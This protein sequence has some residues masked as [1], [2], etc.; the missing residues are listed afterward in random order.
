MRLLRARY[1]N[2]IA[3]LILVITAAIGWNG[4][5]LCVTHHS[6]SL[7]GLIPCSCPSTSDNDAQ[8]HCDAEEASTCTCACSVGSPTIPSSSADILSWQARTVA[9]E[10]ESSLVTVPMR[11]VVSNIVPSVHLPPSPNRLRSVILLI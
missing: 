3:C 1:L 7:L 6:G 10:V 4:L 5:G 8:N 11:R 2:P 9:M